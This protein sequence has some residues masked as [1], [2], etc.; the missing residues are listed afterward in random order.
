MSSPTADFFE[1]IGRRGH[2]RLL[3]GVT[4]TVWFDLEHD[5]EVEGWFLAIKGG[6]IRVSR[7]ERPAD[8]VVRGSRTAFDR[9]VSGKS[10]IYSA[11]VRNELRAEGDVRL[12]R[13]LQRLMPGPTGAHHPREFVHERRRLA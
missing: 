8:C 6:D 5:H 4:G 12:A 1:D 9:V 3:T 13:L 11:W 7:E 10:H 2:E